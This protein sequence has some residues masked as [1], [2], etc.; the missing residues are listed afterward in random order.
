MQIGNGFIR[1]IRGRLK[2]E[3]GGEPVRDENGHTM[4]APFLS[5]LAIFRY[6]PPEKGAENA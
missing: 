3:F 5:M 4:G 1:F 6:K 2:F